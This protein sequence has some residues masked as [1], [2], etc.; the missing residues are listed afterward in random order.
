MHCATGSL[1]TET[2]ASMDACWVDEEELVGGVVGTD[3]LGGEDGLCVVGPTLVGDDEDFEDGWLDGDE[4]ELDCEP[5]ELELDELDELEELVELDE[6]EEELVELE[7]EIVGA[8]PESL[9]VG[10][11]VG[12]PAV[13]VNPPDVGL[14]GEARWVGLL[15]PATATAVTVRMTAATIATAAASLALPGMRR[16]DERLAAAPPVGPLPPP[17]GAS[18]S[19]GPSGV[20]GPS[21]SV[22]TPP[23]ATPPGPMNPNSGSSTAISWRPRSSHSTP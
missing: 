4:G 17:F 5:K 8:A 20:C 10:V 14:G 22:S 3:V 15:L 16:S 2:D 13:G 6:L 19:S 1:V 12:L 23:A 7:P 18:R 11:P 21:A 9:S